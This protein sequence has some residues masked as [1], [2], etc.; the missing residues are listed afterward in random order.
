MNDANNMGNF[1]KLIYPEFS[2][3]ITGVLFDTHNN[4]GRFCN[5]Q[6]YSDFIENEF[7]KLKIEYER[8]KILPKF[9]QA[10]HKGRNRIDFLIKNEIVLEIKAKRLILREDYYQTRRYLTALNKN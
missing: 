1:T 3:K 9:F 7:K 8:E 4:L 6:Q 10:E 2:Y 5:E